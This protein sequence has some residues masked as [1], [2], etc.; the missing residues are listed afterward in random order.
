MVV[1]GRLRCWSTVILVS[2]L[3]VLGGCGAKSNVKTCF[4]TCT[5]PTEFLY[6]T[7]LNDISSFSLNPVGVPTLLGNQSGPNSSEGIVVDASGKYLYVSDFGNSNVD[8][9]TIN[10]SGGLT[11]VSGSPFPA[12]S[13]SGGIAVDPGTKFLYVTLVNTAQVAGFSINSSGALTPMSTSPFSAGNT[14]F[15]AIVDPTGS[16]LY[17]SNLNDSLGSIS[18]YTIDSSSGALTAIAGS[19]FPTQAG[20]PG[21]NGLAIG[22]GGKFL[23][24]AMS[25]SV[26]ANNVVSAFSIDPATGILTQLANSPFLTGSDPQRAATDPSGKFLFTANAQDNTV[27]A[28]TVDGTSGDLTAVAGSPFPLQGAP[29][30]L[31]V[32]PTG[33]FLFVANSGSSGLSAFGVNSTSGVLSPI[34]GSPFSTGQSLN[35]VAIA[36]AQ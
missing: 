29:A 28:F 18:A 12:G 36:R 9:F 20:F 13:A 4:G 27:S 6:A 16:F 1:A 3:T 31:A 35:G 11:A 8:A 19:P 22:A 7:E 24:V 25:G 33:G 14:P 10:A 23:Y 34:S 5:A 32:D 21:P 2:W 17:V 26:N 30:G 15:Q